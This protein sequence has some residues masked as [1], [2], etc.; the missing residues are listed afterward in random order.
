MHQIPASKQTMSKDVMHEWS[1]WDEW[2]W[3]DLTQTDNAVLLADS[4]E[5]TKGVHVAPQSDL[6][7]WQQAYVPEYAPWNMP[8]NQWG[9]QNPVYVPDPAMNPPQM[10]GVAQA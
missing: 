5:F 10:G 1:K 9:G 6:P 3:G 8:V 7:R 2:S 4:E